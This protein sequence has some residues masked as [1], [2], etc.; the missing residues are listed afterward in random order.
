MCLGSIFE[1]HNSL[2]DTGAAIMEWQLQSVCLCTCYIVEDHTGVNLKESPL[3]ILNEWSLN[4]GKQVAVTTNS[5]SNIKIACRLLGWTRLSCL[6]LS[7]PILQVWKV[8]SWNF[9]KEE[10]VK[11]SCCALMVLYLCLSSI[12]RV[13]HMLLKGS[14]DWEKLTPQCRFIPWRWRKRT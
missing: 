13:V 14:V 5:G 9:K 11:K 12:Y 4:P 8:R 1:V 10:V 7:V 6:M 2:L 3:E